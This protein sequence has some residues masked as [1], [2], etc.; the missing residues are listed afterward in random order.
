[1]LNSR[2]VCDQGLSR[3]TPLRWLNVARLYSSHKLICV[4]RYAMMWSLV[5]GF[6]RMQG[7][8]SMPVVCA[9]PPVRH[10]A[11]VAKHE[12]VLYSCC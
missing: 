5:A 12:Q 3:N 1:M 6:E 4:T 10:M 8:F 11:P 2:F 9:T 7:P